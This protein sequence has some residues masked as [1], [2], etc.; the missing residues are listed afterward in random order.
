MQIIV[1]TPQNIAKRAAAIYQEIL[2]A[3]PN[4]ILGFATGSTPLDLYAELVRLN[5]AGEISF[6]D[7]T[8]FNLDEYVGLSPEHDQSYRYFMEHNLFNHIDIDLARTHVPSGLDVSDEALAGYDEAIKAAGGVDMQ[9]LGIGINGHIGFNE[10]GTPL[11][12]LT[13]VVTLTESTREANKRFFASID[14]VP[15]HAATMGIK[16]VMN[17]RKIMLIA[18]G[19]NKADAIRATIKGPVTPDCPASV[20]QLHPDVVVFL[21]EGAASKL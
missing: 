13:H 5:K 17:A 10:P 4:A 15:T 9:L 7:V 19:E 8:S 18:L 11:E 6:K 12:S 16:T 21:D 14:E 3:K 20:L 1:D 2:A